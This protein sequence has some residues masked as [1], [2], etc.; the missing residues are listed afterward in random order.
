MKSDSATSR[1]APALALLCALGGGAFLAAAEPVAPIARVAEGAVSLDG[2]LMEWGALAEFLD[3]RADWAGGPLSLRRQGGAAFALR[4]SETALYVAVRVADVA[5]E[6]PFP[7]EKS[8]RGDCVELFFDFRPPNAPAAPGN[9]DY[10]PGMYRFLLSPPVAGRGARLYAGVAGWAKATGAEIAGARTEDG[11]TLELRIPFAGLNGL[12]AARL[13]EPIGFDLMIDDHDPP[14]GAK[15]EP[16]CRYSFSRGDSAFA[17][18]PLARASTAAKPLVPYARVR[19]PRLLNLAGKSVVRAAVVIAGAAPAPTID[20]E[21]RFLASA[22]DQFTWGEDGQVMPAPEPL[23]EPRF[24]L[25]PLESV[26]VAGL[27]MRVHSRTLE[28]TT[29]VG[30]CYEFIMDSSVGGRQPPARYYFNGRANAGPA[31]EPVTAELR[32]GDTIAELAKCRALLSLSDYY[33]ED[34]NSVRVEARFVP[35]LPAACWLL[36]Q[37]YRK[38]AALPYRLRFILTPEGGGRELW[39]VESPVQPYAPLALDM[40]LSGLPLGIYQLRLAIADTEGGSAAMAPAELGS[41]PVRCPLVL[42]ETR[43]R[44]IRTTLADA[45]I[46]LTRALRLGSPNRQRFPK[47]DPPDAFA[48]TVWDLHAFGGRI[49]IGCGDW[50]ANRGPVDIYSF[51]SA[52]DPAQ[53]RFEKE[54]TV[55]DESVDVFRD[56]GGTLYVPG[57]D[58]KENWSWGNL[59][60]KSGGKWEKHRSIPNGIHVFDAA[61]YNGRLYVGAGTGHGAALFVSSDGARTFTEVPSDPAEAGWCVGRFW[62]LLPVG[63]ELLVLGQDIKRGGF[64]LV[65][66]KVRPLYVPL[67]PGCAG[68]ECT[69]KRLQRFGH[70]GLYTLRMRGPKREELPLAPLL[71][72][73]KFEHGAAQVELFRDKFVRDIVVHGATCHVLTSR[74]TVNGFEGAVYS[75]AD[76]V[77]WTRVALFDVPAPPTS[78]EVLDGKFFVGLGTAGANSG[79]TESGSVWLLDGPSSGSPSKIQ[80]THGNHP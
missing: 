34:R 64:R 8:S 1:S 73:E 33:P 47:D 36:S 25:G 68:E 15:P 29:A 21:P 23:A 2:R 20:L 66:G 12:D 37:E 59:Y 11:Y 14:A 72:I 46:L 43:S 24:V 39:R 75:S 51:A 30:G 69:P 49:Y 76:L 70:C 61:E 26:E 65:D 3:I 54:F 56:Y 52:A 80:T 78:M 41:V 27:G 50:N 40:P 10:A 55:N 67:A 28:I 45:P 22:F 35:S 79:E 5:V 44:L 7:P 9:A 63:G 48:R 38:S 74:A 31:F 32:S 13:D 18:A 4:A 17:G 58:A 71:V 57:I 42:A 19:P 77:T 60:R 62:A 53:V 16:P 6:N